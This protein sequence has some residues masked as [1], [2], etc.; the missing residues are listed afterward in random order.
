MLDLFDLYAAAALSGLSANP[1]PLAM[2]QSWEERAAFAAGQAAA[3]LRA[4]Q[5]HF[6]ELAATGAPF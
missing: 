5:D 2:N 4:R 3:M 6:N 1:A